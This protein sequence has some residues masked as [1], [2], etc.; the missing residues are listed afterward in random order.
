MPKIFMK[1]T[2]TGLQPIGE[3][4]YFDKLRLGD[5]VEVDIKKPRNVGFHRKFFSLMNLVHQNQEEL[6]NFEDF[7]Y[8]FI[9][10][11]GYYRIVETSKGVT[12][13]PKSISFSKMD[14]L[15][16]EE[17]FEKALTVAEQTLGSSK[18][19]IRIALEEY[20]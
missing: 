17:F 18:E 6:D 8:V 7:R 2:L 14:D 4:K 10:R 13:L 3:S 1:K 20:Y 5:E 19:E 9:M 11:C 15:E 16:F 12:Y